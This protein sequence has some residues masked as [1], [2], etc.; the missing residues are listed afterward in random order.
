M[1]NLIK[2]CKDC[3]DRFPG[4]HDKYDKYKYEKQQMEELKEKINSEKRIK[5]DYMEFKMESIKKTTGKKYP[6]R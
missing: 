2:C 4:C 6:V 3:G 1:N 5:N